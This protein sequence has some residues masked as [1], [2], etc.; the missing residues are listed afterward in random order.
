MISVGSVSALHWPA[1]G[2]GRVTERPG[3]LLSHCVQARCGFLY[4]IIKWASS[5]PFWFI[6]AKNPSFVLCSSSGPHFVWIL[7]GFLFCLASHSDS[8]DKSI[9]IVPGWSCFSYFPCETLVPDNFFFLPTPPSPWLSRFLL[10]E[11][12]LPPVTQSVMPLI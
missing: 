2:L 7:A 6:Y 5:L 12:Y 4:L 9:Y 8:D 11:P 10:E 3:R 1:S